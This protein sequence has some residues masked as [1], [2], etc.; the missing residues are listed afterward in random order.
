MDSI[1]KIIKEDKSWSSRARQIEIY[2]SGLV[3]KNPEWSIR[4]TA[5]AL[6]MCASTVCEDLQLAKWLIEDSSL[7]KYKLRKEALKFIHE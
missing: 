1:R 2:H 7:E 5:K 6:K 3:I 4:K